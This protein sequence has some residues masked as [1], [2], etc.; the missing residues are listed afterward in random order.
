M[1]QDKL[2]QLASAE[3]CV[4]GAGT[5]NQIGEYVTL[6]LRADDP[7]PP[8]LASDPFGGSN[9]MGCHIKVTTTFTGSTAFAMGGF[10]VVASPAS[11]PGAGQSPGARVIGASEIFGGATITGASPL[12]GMPAAGEEIFFWL[13]PLVQNQSVT[14]GAATIDVVAADG[15]FTR[16]SGSYLTDGFLIGRQFTARGFDEPGNNC[17]K[18]IQT[19]TATVLTVTDTDGLVD[20]SGDADE[21]IKS[22]GAS[23][24]RHLGLVF[25]TPAYPSTTFSITAG[26]VDAHI[27]TE[28]PTS[29]RSLYDTT[30]A[31]H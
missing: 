21:I 31:A 3:S 7:V 9:T 18:I 8:W 29:L 23:Y 28:I 24:P 22:G 17:T 11:T 25:W 2:L 15:T 19:L 6:A 20:E 4:F 27:V 10:L 1:I 13:N 16:S 5:F 26:A 30:A 12:R 14:T